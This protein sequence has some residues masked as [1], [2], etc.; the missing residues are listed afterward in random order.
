M[1][2]A[3]SSISNGEEMRLGGSRVRYMRTSRW[4]H[5]LENER[6]REER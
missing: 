5:A 2:A 6:R 4:L 1:G 3:A